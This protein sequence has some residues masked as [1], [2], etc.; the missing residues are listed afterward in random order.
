MYRLHEVEG[1]EVLVSTKEGPSVLLLGIFWGV[2]KG[3]G[4][5]FGD[6]WAIFDLVMQLVKMCA[7]L[8]LADSVSMHLCF[9][10]LLVTKL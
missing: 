6:S 7:L 2:Y 5:S 8:I 4:A 10:N 1:P 9:I 3:G